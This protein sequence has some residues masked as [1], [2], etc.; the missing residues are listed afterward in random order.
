M[1]I[2]AN[3]D[4]LANDIEGQIEGFKKRRNDNKR[5]AANIVIAG[6]V[7][8]AV[9]TILIGISTTISNVAYTKIFS[10]LAIVASSSLAILQAWDGLFNHK[11]LWAQYADTLNRLYEIETDIRHTKAKAEHDKKEIEQR[12]ID[13]L[14]MKYKDILR[15]TNEQW[16]KLRI[17]KDEK[18]ILDKINSES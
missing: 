10:V 6:S 9:T 15:G 11:R 18:A 12:V 13:E 3:L 7:I 5:K 1:S 2:N 16:L 17:E 8:S 4:V 14:Y